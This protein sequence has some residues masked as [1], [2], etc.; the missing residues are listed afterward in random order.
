VIQIASRSVLSL[1]QR[2][3]LSVA[4]CLRYVSRSSGKIHRYGR[5]ISLSPTIPDKTSS[6]ALQKLFLNSNGF[7]VLI[8]LL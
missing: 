2:Q 8:P 5:G 1:L 4:H 6:S 7:G 3:I